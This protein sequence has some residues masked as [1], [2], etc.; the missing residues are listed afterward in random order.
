VTDLGFSVVETMT[1]YAPSIVGTELTRDI[2]GKLEAVEVGAEKE[3][4]LLRETVRSIAEQ[5]A[6]LG[7]NE[8]A[9]GREIDSA[10]MKAVAKSFVLG[11]CPVCNTGELRIIRSR[12]TKKRF[13][14]CS[15]Y[16]SSCRASAPLPQKGTIK[17]TTK[18]CEHCSW[19]VIYVTGGRRPWRLCV[20][21]SCP[22]KKKS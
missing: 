18:T 21:P 2:E 7:A 6:E 11:R 19:P 16:P 13:V 22:G 9:V 1:K 5:L 8:E 10:M 15:N 17:T 14:G 3:A 12:A 4:D 20:N